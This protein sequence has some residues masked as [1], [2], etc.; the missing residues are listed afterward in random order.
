VNGGLDVRYTVSGDARLAYTILGKGPHVIV[1]ISSWASNQD[2]RAFFHV[3]FWERLGSFARLVRYDQRG[4]GLSDPVGLNESPTL[5]GWTNDLQAIVEAAEADEVVLYAN[6]GAGPVGLFY[7]AV[8]P[9]RTRGLI[10]ANS[11]AAVAWSTDYP[12]GLRPDEYGRFVAYMLRARGTGQYA[13]RLMP[14]VAVDDT[15]LREL[16]SVERQGASPGAFQAVL[17]QLYATDVRSI[18]P[19]ITAPTL[20]MHTVDNQ[21]IPVAHGRYLAQGI[22]GARLIE[23][24]GGDQIE[25][26]SGSPS[27]DLAVDEIEEFVTGTRTSADRNRMLTTLLFTDVVGST[28]RVAAVGDRT[29]RTVLN[30]HDDVVLRQLTRFLG[31]QQ[32]FTGDGILATF[33]GPARAIRC[34]TAI[35]DA[36]RQIGLDIRVGIHTGEVERR[37]AE[38]AGIAVHLA[39]RVCETAEAGEVLVSRTVVDLV[40]GSGIAFNDRGEHDLKGIPA[41]WRLFAV[42]T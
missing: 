11:F 23:L 36:A 38:L 13:R 40:A 32:K 21:F 6:G 31:E 29:W 42:T 26:A 1:A 35:R 34:G 10:L 9:E 28:D 18:L 41:T 25:Y 12:A 2:V 7:A 14:G 16:A 30:S 3:E 4:S 33:D 19:V 24:P 20:V 27:A 8:H 5:E 17:R 22:P 37:G 39:H 15:R